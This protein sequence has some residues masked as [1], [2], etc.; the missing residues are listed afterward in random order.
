MKKQKRNAE[1]FDVL[2]LYS[3]LSHSYG[4]KLDDPNSYEDF[5]LRIGEALRKNGSSGTVVHGKR[6][7]SMF[8]FLVA[9]L[10]KSIL[11]KQ[12]DSGDMYY[13]QDTLIAPDFRVV[14]E[15]GE[16]VLVEVKNCHNK[17]PVKMYKIDERYY[18][19]LNRHALING[20]GL[21]FA[22]YFSFFNK[23]V[24][25]SIENFE[26]RGQKYLINFFKALACSEMSL[27]GDVMIGTKPPLEIIFWADENAESSI[28]EDDHASFTIGATSFYCAGV[29]V[30]D[31]DEK[32]VM[33]N[34]VRFG[35]WVESN[36]IVVQEEG[37]VVSA[38]FKYEPEINQQ[39]D[40]AI[41]G[42]FSSF[43]SNAYAS[44]TVKDGVVTALK[45]KIDPSSLDFSIPEDYNS[46]ALPLLRL[47]I[48]P[49]PSASI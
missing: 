5:K 1:Y 3:E 38:K 30:T 6:I 14:L 9:C 35:E 16:T 11:V 34:L 19:K 7:E 46:K 41:I 22:I 27:V 31:K 42:S 18:D 47:S 48:Q 28:S 8:G 32:E 44:T 20:V 29:E 12:E 10:R 49:N 25:L 21:K 43:I 40:I 15:S 39:Q 13:S 37:R 45:T 36:P 4:Y 2:E 17:D 23:W 33:L 24:L 26:K